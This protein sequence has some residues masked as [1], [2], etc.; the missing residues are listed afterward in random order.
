MNQSNITITRT[1]EDNFNFLHKG[2]NYYVALQGNGFAFVLQSK[3]WAIPTYGQARE[4]QVYIGHETDHEKC[5][6]QITK[7]MAQNE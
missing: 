3:N 2:H 1:D 6:E 5:A 4:C 7:E